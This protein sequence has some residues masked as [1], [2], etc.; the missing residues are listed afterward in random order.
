M[1]ETYNLKYAIVSKNLCF[2]CICKEKKT[3]SNIKIAMIECK[4]TRNWKQV[5]SSVHKV[6][7]YY[8]GLSVPTHFDIFLN[9]EIK[10]IEI[11]DYTF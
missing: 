3:L 1:S 5:E 7:L 11:F 6:I 2:T 8:T 9:H 10:L 4:E